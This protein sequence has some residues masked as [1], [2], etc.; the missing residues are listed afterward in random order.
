MSDARGK[1]VIGYEGRFDCVFDAPRE[2]EVS[3]VFADSKEPAA[4]VR[5]SAVHDRDFNRTR[6]IPETNQLGIVTLRLIPGE[7]RID[8]EPNAHQPYLIATAPIKVGKEKIALSVSLE[9]AA[10]VKLRAIAESKRPISGIRLVAW[11]ETRP[12]WQ[13]LHSHPSFVDHPGT[14][15]EGNVT[16]LLKPGRYQFAHKLNPNNVPKSD[17][18]WLDLKAGELTTAEVKGSAACQRIRFTSRKRTGR[19]LA[20]PAVARGN[21]GEMGPAVSA[22]ANDRLAIEFAQREKRRGEH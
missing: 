3:I 2:V 18:N 15:D 12:V 22:A 20:A 19:R 7:Y 16:A 13:P 17:E 8:V 6:V 1:A 9:P 14:D 11:S 4:D 21:C 10:K 5:V